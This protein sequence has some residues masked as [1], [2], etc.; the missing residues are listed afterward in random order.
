MSNL[1]AKYVEAEKE[2]K[3]RVAKV[4]KVYSKGRQGVDQD[5]DVFVEMARFVKSEKELRSA[6]G[7]WGGSLVEFRKTYMN[8]E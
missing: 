5:D 3:R 1:M 2:F 6:L 4:E 8:Y 7:L